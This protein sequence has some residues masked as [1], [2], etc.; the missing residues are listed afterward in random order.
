MTRLSQA[1]ST[2]SHR[3]VVV[4]AGIAGL[5]AAFRLQR[6]GIDVTVL[7]ASDRVG[8]RMTVHSCNGYRIEPGASLLFGSY[9]QMLRLVQ[10]AGLVDQITWSSATIG[11]L[12][13]GTIHRLRMSSPGALLRSELL[14]RRSK[15]LLARLAVDRFRFGRR[16]QWSDMTGGLALDPYS[17]AA[18]TSQRLNQELYDYLVEPLCSTFTLESPDHTSAA[19]LLYIVKHFLA[20]QM[21]NGNEGI[22]FLPQGLAAQLDVKLNSSVT[23]V[24]PRKGGVDITWT[25]RS[26]TS[27][28]LAADACVLA[29]PGHHIPQL[30]P[31]LTTPQKDVFSNLQYTR[32]V[33]V[34]LGLSQPPPEP[35]TVVA[36]PQRES[37]DLAAIVFNHNKSPNR[38]PH[39][40]GLITTHWRSDWR[41]RR[42]DQDDDTIA[43]AAIH[44]TA[45]LFPSIADTVDMVHVHRW[46]PCVAVWPPGAARRMARAMSSRIEPRVEFA[47]DYFA[48][49]SSNAS[50]VSGEAAAQRLLTTLNTSR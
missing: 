35:T 27:Q 39:G 8:G 28:T 9:R 30:Y 25:P 50:V 19:G 10:D 32:T 16:I 11:I 48:P 40:K 36:V 17:A 29:I 18:Y 34:F 3:V 5:T 47:G 37:P 31:S 6:A 20:G 49:S 14:S 7:E 41:H 22:D 44:G 24:T 38:A 45:K 43:Q 21:F 4:G 23:N 1:A 12:R 46:E 2:A 13:E 15:T 42:W 33:D 26:G